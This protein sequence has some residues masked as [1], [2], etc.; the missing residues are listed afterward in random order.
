MADDRL[1]GRAG[2]DTTDFKTGLATMNRELRVL[3]SGFRASAAS[4]GDWASDATGLESR[5]KSLNSQMDVQRQK[6]ALTRAEYERIAAEKGE[7]SRAAQDLEIKLNKEVE[8]LGKMESELRDTEGALNEMQSGTEEAGE[9]VDEMGDQADDASS[10]FSVFGDVLES[11]KVIA[12]GIVTVVAAIATAVS[13]AALAIGGLVFNA[14]EAAGQLVDLST[15]TGISTTRLQEL[16]YVGNQVGTSLDTIT[17]AQSRLVRSMATAQEQ[18]AKFDEQLAN[19]VMEDE[20]NVPIEMA[21]AFNGLGVAFTDA[22]GQLRDSEDVFADIIDKLGTIPN[23]AERDALAMQIFGKSAQELNPLIKTGSAELAR[24]ADEAH[25]MGAVMDEEAVAGLE[26]FGDMVTSIQDGVKGLL[27]SLAAD[28][29]P[30]FQEVASAIQ[31]LFKSDAFKQGLEQFSQILQ[32]VVN[33]VLNILQK[34]L[35]GDFEGALTDMFGVENTAA[36]LNLVDIVRTF[37]QDTVLPF[38]NTHA[39]SISVSLSDIV[40][41][42]ISLITFVTNLYIAWTTAWFTIY[43]VLI[44]VWEG[45]LKPVFDALWGFLSTTIPAALQG[46][47]AVWT[48]TLLPAIQMVWGFIQSDLLPLFQAVAT[49][50]DAVFGLAVR[51]LAGIWENVLL[52]PLQQVFG[53][54]QD[55]LLPIFQEI[56]EFIERNVQP[57]FEALGDF[58]SNSLVP[59]FQG[60]SGAISDSIGWLQ[61]MAGSMNNLELPP[62]LTP[63]SPTPW[64]TGLVG[65]NRQIRE[66]NAQLPSLANGLNLQPGGL[67][68]GLASAV[69][70]SVNS[71][72]QVIG[73]VIIRGDTPAGSLGSELR[74]RRY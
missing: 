51:V 65:I 49:F 27:G 68:L 10:Q 17:G 1:S 42:I 22:G 33:D 34:L 55:N 29:L 31:G 50:L 40:G 43:G 64:E 72:V 9:A 73:N 38:V 45:F 70:Q 3:E 63:G 4:I 47:S 36:I 71:N 54:I 30:L 62:W 52:P 67:P 20:I 32:V 15:K 5:I 24:L 56:S 8:T 14:A 66:L 12:A 59:A 28:F 16:Q 25:A 58:L 23:E 69:D 44:S 35:S 60:I 74:G 37:I 61:E 48:G 41:A 11:T 39:G 2:L 26:G 7:N 18:Q 19:G 57:V 21:A 6:V 53:V 46:L 13:G